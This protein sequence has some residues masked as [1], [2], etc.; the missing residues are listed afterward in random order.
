MF[1][2]DLLVRSNYWLRDIRYIPTIFT[3]NLFGFDADNPI[4]NYYRPLV[5]VFLMLTYHIFGPHPWGF[6]LV[7]ILFHTANSVLVFLLASSLHA[8]FPP[9]NRGGRL[10]PFSAAF[11]C[12]LLFATHPVHTE[13]VAWVAGLSD[14]SYTCFYLISL[15]LYIRSIR[16]SQSLTGARTLSVYAFFLAMLCKEPALTLPALLIAHDLALGEGPILAAG[17]LKR[18]LP[19]LAAA[20]C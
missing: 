1:D 10:A 9:S 19:Y 6:H 11:V 3:S 4:C 14:V 13:A 17:T 18:Y 7:N 12:A 16:T 2:D 5:N 20:A 15:F 8:E